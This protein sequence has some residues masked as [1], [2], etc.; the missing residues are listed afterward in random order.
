MPVAQVYINSDIGHSETIQKYTDEQPFTSSLCQ[1]QVF[2]FT[3]AST[4]KRNH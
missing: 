1:K 2:L 4:G 3:T